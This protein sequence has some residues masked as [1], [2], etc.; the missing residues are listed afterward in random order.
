MLRKLL[1]LLLVTML[2]DAHAAAFGG[3]GDGGG[4]QPTAYIRC[5]IP[6]PRRPSDP[7]NVD[8]YFDRND[9]Y[10][11]IYDI[12]LWQGYSKGDPHSW[13]MGVRMDTRHDLNIGFVLMFKK[14][15]LDMELFTTTKGKMEVWGTDYT[16]RLKIDNPKYFGK[17]IPETTLQCAVVD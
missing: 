9:P 12:V 6:D 5:S 3:V 11:P 2:N 17:V 10:S 16:V 4:D 13:I 15:G 14:A 8:V 7:M 1:T